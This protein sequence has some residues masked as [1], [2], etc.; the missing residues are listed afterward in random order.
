MS[1]YRAISTWEQ[2]E[3]SEISLQPMNFDP[4]IDM[5]RL[6][7]QTKSAFK[8]TAPHLRDFARLKDVNPSLRGD[9]LLIEWQDYDWKRGELSKLDMQA[10][11][12]ALVKMLKTKPQS[13]SFRMLDCLG[14]FADNTAYRFGLTSAYLGTTT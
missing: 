12:E 4:P 9:S 13:D 2:L 8:N 3:S 1:A 7:L 10:R 6:D 5:L 11:V 14:Y